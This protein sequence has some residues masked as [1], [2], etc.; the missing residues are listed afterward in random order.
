MAPVLKFY[1][2]RHFFLQ[3]I[4]FY[5]NPSSF[6]MSVYFPVSIV[7]TGVYKIKNIPW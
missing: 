1:P 2:E 3:P 4:H 7:S 5:N 6:T